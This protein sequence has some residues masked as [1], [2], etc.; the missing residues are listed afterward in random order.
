MKF[1]VRSMIAA[2]GTSAL[3]TMSSYVSANEV[4]LKVHH[5]LSPLTVQQTGMIEPWCK[6]IETESNGR[7]KCQIYPAMMLGGTP[8]MLYQQAVDGVA[9]VILTATGYAAGRFPKV[10]V[11]ELPFMM[12]NT[13]AT[14]KAAWDFY[15]MHA[16]AD[17]AETK[18][19]AAF[20]HGPGNV[21]TVKKK[22][23]TDEDFKGIKLRA[24]TRLTTKMVGALGA[25]PVAMPPPQVPE[26]LTRGIVDGGFFT[27]EL[28]PAIKLSELTNFVGEPDVK[29][30]ALYTTFFVFAM[31]K[32]KYESLPDDLKRVIDKNSGQK[33]SVFLG[34]AQA[35]TDAPG[36]QKMLDAGKHV[37]VITSAELET[38]IP[39]AKKVEDE[40]IE[41]VAKKNIDGK[42][43]INDANTL[44]KKYT[45]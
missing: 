44:I 39:A 18:I 29:H 2:I 25:T 24:P 8:S 27:Y 42:K 28:V 43:L 37:T 17:F 9:D 36:K 12:T 38:W 11:F 1:N 6:T 35:A 3:L 7:I 14:S 23:A 33:L 22:I 34:T 26:A 10:E 45:K 32:A 20:V 13:E 5:F 30:K 40:W 19:L 31:N 41:E 16:K 4:I 15:E 21:F